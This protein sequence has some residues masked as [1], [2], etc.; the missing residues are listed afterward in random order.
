MSRISTPTVAGRRVCALLAASSAVLH[1]A[2]VGDVRSAV[3]AVV[4]VGMTVACLYCAKELWTAG[5]PRVWCI[6]AV[7]NLAMVAVHW[8]MPGHHHGQ[9]VSAAPAAA[10]TS[11]LMAVATSIAILEA[12]IATV[13]LWV[14][15][16][17]RASSLALAARN[18]GAI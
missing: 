14:Q 2:M 1:G 15:T 6:V 17:S 9:T 11:T 18:R 7:M 10:A 16:R 4:V 5:S 13:V 12:V 3:L 8:S